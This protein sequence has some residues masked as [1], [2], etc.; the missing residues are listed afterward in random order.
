MQRTARTWGWI[1]GQQDAFHVA[2]VDS[3]GGSLA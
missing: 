3:S 1:D 2:S